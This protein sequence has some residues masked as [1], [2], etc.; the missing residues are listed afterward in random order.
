[1]IYSPLTIPTKP[2]V[3]DDHGQIL[4]ALLDLH[5]DSAPNAAVQDRGR[6][7]EHTWK[8]NFIGHRLQ[9]AAFEVR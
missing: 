7:H 3:P 4:K 9:F 8:L 2:S 1:M 5:H 6:R